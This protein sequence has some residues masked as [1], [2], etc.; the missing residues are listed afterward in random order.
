MDKTTI[1]AEIGK[2][3]LYTEQELSVEENLA[4]AKELVSAA[5]NSNADIVKFQCHVF[6][7]EAR[8]RSETRHEWIRRNERS[9]PYETFWKPLRA[10]CGEVGIS[11]LVTPMSKMAAEKIN[12][13]V[14]QWKIG[15]GDITDLE[16]LEYVARSD[17][18]IILSSGMSL[19][20][21][22]DHAVSLIRQFNTNLTILQCTSEYPCP[23]DK[24][25]LNV[26]KEY[27]WRYQT[28]DIGFSDHTL[29]LTIP[30]IAVAMGAVCIEKHLC[31]NNNDWGPD[32]KA[33][34]L[35]EEFKEMVENIR[36]TEM[37]MGDGE[38]KLTQEE[39][40]FRKIFRKI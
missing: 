23:E 26:M 33:S 27:E 2:N 24:V 40:R 19:L 29:S 1:I 20:K 4:K 10:F 22:L 39:V 18:P 17:K 5:K 36:W 8:K 28:K 21:E 9:T 38:K 35:P 31:L 16:L 34:L 7:D 25:N 12:D 13:L 15:S 14:D 3:F 6:E 11:F 37:V 30:A 32:H